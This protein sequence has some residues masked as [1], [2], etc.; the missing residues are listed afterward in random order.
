LWQLLWQLS[1]RAKT[2][3]LCLTLLQKDRID[4]PIEVVN[5]RNM[6]LF[7]NKEW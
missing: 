6:W 5:G 7:V 2:L 4:G 1:D 3:A